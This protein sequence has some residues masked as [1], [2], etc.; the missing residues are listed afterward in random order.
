MRMTIEGGRRQI[1]DNLPYPWA[2][3]KLANQLS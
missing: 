1:D 3:V 2:Q